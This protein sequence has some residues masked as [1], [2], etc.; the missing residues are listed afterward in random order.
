METPSVLISKGLHGEWGDR[1]T[2]VEGGRMAGVSLRRIKKPY[3]TCL[4]I[5]LGRYVVYCRRSRVQPVSMETPS[6]LISKGLHGE[7]GDRR[8]TVEGGRMAGVSLRRIKKPYFTCLEI[9]LF[10][11]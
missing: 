10:V 7:W 2:T 1:R 6:V 4:E 3:F 9:V 5:V 8:T 11:G